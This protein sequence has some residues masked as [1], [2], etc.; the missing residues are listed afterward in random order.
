MQP[1]AGTGC[2]SGGV[3]L[4]REREEEW[5]KGKEGKKKVT[6]GERGIKRRRRGRNRDGGLR[7]TLS[8]SLPLFFSFL[9]FLGRPNLV[10]AQHVGPM[11]L[12][13]RVN[14]EI[15]RNYKRGSKVQ[16]K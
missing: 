7:H 5:K 3:S 12:H 1:I 14:K 8:F 10:Q 6:K 4:T 15:P 2:I 13:S 11:P 16:A 9:F